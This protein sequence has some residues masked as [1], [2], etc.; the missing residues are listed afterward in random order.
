M[1]ERIHTGKR[2]EGSL[3]VEAAFVLPL[4]LYFIL[5]F[6]YFIQIFMVQEYIQQAITR[7]SLDFAKTAYVYEDF[8]G[9]TE[10]M[11]FDVTVFGN[12]LE[13]GLGDFTASLMDKT[14]LKTFSGTYLNTDFINHSCVEKG[15]QGISFEDSSIL[16]EGDCIDIVISYRA[17]P[18]IKLFPIH[19]MKLLQRMR[20][21]GWTGREV[22]ATYSMEEE[23]SEEVTVYITETGRVYH[24]SAA[25]S[26]IRLSIR[27]VNGIPDSYRNANGSKYYACKECCDRNSLP[28]GTYFITEDGSSYHAVRSCPTLKRTVKQIPL[29]KVGS[30]TPCKRCYTSEKKE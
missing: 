4:F 22:A 11:N 9:I 17:A 10:A 6:L 28:S 21:R 29:S 1:I 26:H 8:T 23:E 16:K 13:L 3:T 5:A 19:S 18:P 30:R 20:V 2:E 7:M 25:C 14:V 15:F 12:E 27:S 24:K